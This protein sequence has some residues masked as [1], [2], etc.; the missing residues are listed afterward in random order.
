MT[1]NSTTD[2]ARGNLRPPFDSEA[3]RAAQAGRKVKRGGS[4]LTEPT[5]AVQV[6]M[7]ARQ[8][9]RLREL[10]VNRSEVVRKLLDVWLAEQG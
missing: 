9:A 4:P 6:V 1:V 5:E 8:A 3:G 10:G 2:K 7:F